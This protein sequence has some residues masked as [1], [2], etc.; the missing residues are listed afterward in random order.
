MTNKSAGQI[1][2]PPTG[3]FHDRQWALIWP[4]LGSFPWPPTSGQVMQGNPIVPGLTG[5]PP[6]HWAETWSPWA[7]VPE[8]PVVWNDGLLEWGVWWLDQFIPFPG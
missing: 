6:G 4:S 7:G 8:L 2:S 1:S 3:S 5:V